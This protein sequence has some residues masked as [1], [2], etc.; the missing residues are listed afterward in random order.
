[1][2]KW[3]NKAA[4]DDSG[5]AATKDGLPEKARPPRYKLS[6]LEPLEFVFEL[7]SLADAWIANFVRQSGAEP[8]TL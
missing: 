6:L 3:P 2:R 5:P 8:H 1:M 4:A 7:C